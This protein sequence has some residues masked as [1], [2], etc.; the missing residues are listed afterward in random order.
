MRFKYSVINQQV[1]WV[2]AS[3]TKLQRWRKQDLVKQQKTN[4]N[5]NKRILG[6]KIVNRTTK[7]SNVNNW[8]NR[9]EHMVYIDRT[10]EANE[11]VT[12]LKKTELIDRTQT[13]TEIK[14]GLTIWQMTQNVEVFC[15]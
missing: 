4:S 3:V 1:Y 10:V 2:F 15:F 6:D 8:K 5:F 12:H 14:N 11:Q 7:T 13:K 9:T